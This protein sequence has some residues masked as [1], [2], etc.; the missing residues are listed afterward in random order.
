MAKAPPRETAT[1]AAPSLIT[2]LSD[3]FAGASDEEREQLKGL[4]PGMATAGQKVVVD[5]T[6]LSLD[7]QLAL[8]RSTNSKRQETTS[9]QMIVMTMGSVT[10]PANWEPAPPE[11]VTEMGPNA[12][13]LWIIRWHQGKAQGSMEQ[14]RRELGSGNAQ[15]GEDTVTQLEGASDVIGGLKDGASPVTEAPDW[16]SMEHGSNAAAEAAGVGGE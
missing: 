8:V 13:K 16:M 7:E 4:F 10:H 11:H 1:E 14:F 6:N 5:R 3:A 2:Q 9:A 12:E 15:I